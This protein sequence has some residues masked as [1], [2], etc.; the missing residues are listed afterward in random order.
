MREW[1]SI[2]LEM[3]TEKGDETQAL[4]ILST[5][6]ETMTHWS[7]CGASSEGAA[8]AR[9]EMMKLTSKQ[10]R[11]QVSTNLGVAVESWVPP[12]LV[13]CRNERIGKHVV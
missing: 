2:P 13:V 6:A 5:R 11:K 4:S 7:S 9:P 8:V 1:T 10:K 3:K 12:E